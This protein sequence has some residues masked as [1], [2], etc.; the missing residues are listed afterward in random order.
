MQ[1]PFSATLLAAFSVISITSASPIEARQ[2]GT[3]AN[4]TNGAPA[5]NPNPIVT[6]AVNDLAACLS[7]CKGNPSCTA[8]TFQSGTCKLFASTNGRREAEAQGATGAQGGQGG[9]GATNGGAGSGATN[10]TT[11]NGVTGG[12]GSQVGTHAS[13]MNAVPAGS[14]APISTPAVTDLAACLAAC[15]S[16][17]ACIAYTFASNVC[18]LF[19]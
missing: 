2:A 18:D 15:K 6:P 7:A 14:P 17:S 19:D 1:F 3:H 9:Q 12:T 8:Y 16:N 13:P 10:P 11:G 4:P 5:S